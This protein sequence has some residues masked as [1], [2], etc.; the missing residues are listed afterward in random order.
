M[1]VRLWEQEQPRAVL[2][3]WD[4]LE[5]PT[6]RHEAFAAYQSGRE[7]DDSLLEQLDLLPRAVTALSFAVAKAPA[8]RPTTSSPPRSRTRRRAAGRRSSRAATATRSSSSA[9]G[10]TSSSPCAASASSRGSA[11]TRCASATASS[12]SRCPTSSRSAATLRQACPGAKGVGPKTAASLLQQYGTLEAM[13][14]EGRFS[15]QA[16]ELRLYRRIAT[17]DADAPLPEIPDA[18]PDWDG[19][20][21]LCAWGLN[22]ARRQARGGGRDRGLQPSALAELHP[23]GHHPER[24]S[25][26]PRCWRRSRLA[27]GSRRPRGRGPSLPRR[28]ARRARPQRSRRPTWLDAD[29]PACGDDVRGCAA[30]GRHRDRGGAPRRLRA[31]PPAGPPRAAR[32]A[33]WASA[34]STTSRSPRAPRR[35]R[36]SSASRSSTS[37]STTAT[38][39]RTIFWDDDSVFFVSLHEWPFYPGT[40]GPQDSARRRSTFRCR[41]ARATTS[42][43]ARS[44]T[45]SRRRSRPSRRNSCSSRRASMRTSDDPLAGMSITERGFRELARR[46]ASL[47]PRLPRSSRAATTSRRLPAALGLRCRAARSDVR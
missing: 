18:E 43:C 35:R 28:G 34:S 36:A 11:R 16:D 12:R 13:L 10:R 32:T 29:T 9:T 20:A 46:C 2:V 25:G 31:R 14:A 37:T 40:G 33:R 38:A 42:T 27:R 6:Y 1:I 22:A 19:G 7:F 24:P 39:R 44:T 45:P 17:M 30:R 21:A 8:T 41:P 47:A 26:S 4:T 23:T 15:A 3:G 5:V